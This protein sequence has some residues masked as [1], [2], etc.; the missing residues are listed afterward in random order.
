MAVN[1]LTMSV[2]TSGYVS[3]LR[4]YP[5]YIDARV[6][7]ATTN[8][9]VTI[10]SGAT[11]VIFSANADFYCNPNSGTA[12]IPAADVTDGTGSEINPIGYSNLTPGGSFGLIAPAAT[13]V[14]MAFYL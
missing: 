6:L 8:E 7:A 12:A 1:E 3:Y 4:S 10:P 5:T 2:A 14:T 9:E 13:I 11:K